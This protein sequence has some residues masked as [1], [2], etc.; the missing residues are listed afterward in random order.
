LAIIFIILAL[1]SCLPEVCH[2]TASILLASLN[3]PNPQTKAGVLLPMDR[4]RQ[5][6][7]ILGASPQL[8]N[9]PH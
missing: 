5:A 3:H 9:I 1:L 8:G 7:G 6:K 4:K 2:I